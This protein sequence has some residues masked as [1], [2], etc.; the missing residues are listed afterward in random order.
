MFK[1]HLLKFI[2]HL[3]MKNYVINI[4]KQIK[5]KIFIIYIKFN[6]VNGIF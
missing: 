5:R 1:F 4:V 3:Q 2:K 6:M